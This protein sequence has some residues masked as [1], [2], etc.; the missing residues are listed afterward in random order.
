MKNLIAGLR[1]QKVKIWRRVAEELSKPTRKRRTVNLSK[2]E[3]FA[4]EGE[5]VIVPGKVLAAGNLTKRI[6]IAA[7]QFSKKA[8]EMVKKSGSSTTT[9]EGL[10]K[11]NTKGTDVR[12]LG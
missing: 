7:W 10:M 4:K 8:E 1:K 11:R 6:T 9:I 3:R 5:T 2:V 12:I